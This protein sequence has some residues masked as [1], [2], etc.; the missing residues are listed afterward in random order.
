MNI[1]RKTNQLTKL[2]AISGIATGAAASIS[3]ES[4]SAI[5]FNPGES[6]LNALESVMS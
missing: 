6:D 5:T 4:A 2:I 3:V 1:S